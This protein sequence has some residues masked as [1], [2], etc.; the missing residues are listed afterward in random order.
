MV[1][2]GE[3][4]IVEEK[5]GKGTGRVEDGR[6]IPPLAFICTALD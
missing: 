2:G 5:A 1:K 4:F 3:G 6:G